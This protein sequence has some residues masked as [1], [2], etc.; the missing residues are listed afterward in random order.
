MTCH[1]EIESYGLVETSGHSPCEVRQDKT[2]LVLP[3]AI[4]AMEVNS[5]LSKAIVLKEEVQVRHNSVCSLRNEMSFI[6][7]KVHLSRHSL[8]AHP[9]QTTL[10][11]YKKE[12]RARL[13][14]VTRQVDLLCVVETVMHGDLPTA[15][16]TALQSLDSF[17]STDT[18]STGCHLL[19]E[20]PLL[21][22]LFQVILLKPKAVTQ[23]RKR[24]QS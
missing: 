24:M 10:A 21:A 12:Y 9:E 6:N 2:I 16:S 20:S 13:Q 1:H 8:T 3:R 4:V 19:I 23:K 17:L 18:H 15:G 7:E 11:R 14:G 5:G 22:D